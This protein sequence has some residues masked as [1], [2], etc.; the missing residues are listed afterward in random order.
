LPALGLPALGLPALGLPALELPALELPALGLPALGLPALGLPA[1]RQKGLEFLAGSQL[2]L[3]NSMGNCVDYSTIYIY[4]TL[5]FWK[6][7]FDYCR[8]NKI[9]VFFTLALIIRINDFIPLL[10]F[11]L[12][13]LV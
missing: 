5:T 11:N 12:N 9:M 8:R 3:N 7:N 2:L 1:L 4:R 13:K 6:G 10:L